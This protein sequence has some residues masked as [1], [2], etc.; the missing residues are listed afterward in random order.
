MSKEL[1]FKA[2]M[3]PYPQK[4]HGDEAF[5]YCNGLYGD[6]RSKHGKFYGGIKHETIRI[7]IEMADKN[8][9]KIFEGDIVKHRF[10]DGLN[11]Y[12]FEL[13]IIEW[14]KDTARF[15]WVGIND[16]E[17]KFGMVAHDFE[18]REVVGSIFTHPE[19]L[20]PK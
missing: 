2:L 1:E 12:E 11:D 17:N 13:G 4:G 19:L 16:R 20:Q 5:V 8:A 14:D 6:W 10:L 15:A 3:N 9:K 7:Y 18:D